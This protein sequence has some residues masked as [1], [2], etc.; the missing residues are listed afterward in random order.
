M[1]NDEQKFTVARC[2]STKVSG[3]C[4]GCGGHH[5]GELMLRISREDDGRIVLDIGTE[6]EGD[7]TFHVMTC[8]ELKRIPGS[9]ILN[10][11]DVP[12]VPSLIQ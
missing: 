5:V 1:G 12:V 10:L 6:G 4:P 3:L 11:S 9:M 8:V 2:R 7:S